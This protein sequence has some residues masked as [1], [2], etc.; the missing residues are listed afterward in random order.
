MKFKDLTR[1]DIELVKSIAVDRYISKASTCASEEL[2]EAVMDMIH[3]KGFDL[4]KT[5]REPT[6][7]Q[8]R[9]SWYS[10][11]PKTYNWWKDD[12]KS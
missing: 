8:P 12:K 2:V 5:E 4:V 1:F 7:S 11:A 10:P 3:A 6:W 9:E